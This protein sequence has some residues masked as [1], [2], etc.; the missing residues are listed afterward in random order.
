MR[1]VTSR[2]ITANETNHV[3]SLPS[4]SVSLLFSSFYFVYIL[5]PLFPF[6]FLLSRLLLFLLFC[7]LYF[8]LPSFIFISELVIS[9]ILLFLSSFFYFFT[10]L[11]FNLLFSYWTL[12][13]F[14]FS[15]HLFSIFPLSL[16]HRYCENYGW[17]CIQLN[18]IFPKFEGKTRKC[19]HKNYPILLYF[20]PFLITSLTYLKKITNYLSG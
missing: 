20:F 16:A 5:P 10:F 12:V 11:V 7:F 3:L 2:S 13:F 9:L 15:F 8:L 6:S 1:F 18:A 17:A 4:L 19:H 14:L